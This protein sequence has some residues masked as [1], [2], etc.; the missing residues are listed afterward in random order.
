[1][2]SSPATSTNSFLSCFLAPGHTKIMKA[3][4]AYSVVRMNDTTFTSVLKRRVSE[5]PEVPETTSP[6][7]EVITRKES[8][9][10]S[11]SSTQ[12]SRHDI[13][14]QDDVEGAS[15]SLPTPRFSHDRRYSSS[16]LEVHKVAAAKDPWK[17]PPYTSQETVHREPP[18]YTEQVLHSVRVNDDI[19]PVKPDSPKARRKP[20]SMLHKIKK[21]FALGGSAERKSKSKS[22][23][24]KRKLFSSRKSSTSSGKSTEITTDSPSTSGLAYR[25]SDSQNSVETSV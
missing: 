25:L 14:T 4:E 21:P 7:C 12:G 5:I 19:A 13:N 8:I 17:C 18:P 24:D 11:G 10:S 23:H 2:I 15:G 1:M 22:S 9:S 16:F 6:V 20:F 3:L